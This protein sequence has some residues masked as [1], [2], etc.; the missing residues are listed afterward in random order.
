MSEKDENT[1][2][3][4]ILACFALC[5]SHLTKRLQHFFVQFQVLDARDHKSNQLVIKS[6]TTLLRLMLVASDQAPSTFLEFVV[7]LLSRQ[8]LTNLYGA[9]QGACAF[10]ERK[11]KM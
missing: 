4:A 1:A 3:M 6:I 5:L 11:Y 7:F 10:F 2:R 9:E 8:K